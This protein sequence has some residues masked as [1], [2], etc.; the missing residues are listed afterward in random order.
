M[1]VLIKWRNGP[2][3]EFEVTQEMCDQM[4]IDRKNHAIAE[5]EINGV[6]REINWRDVDSGVPKFNQE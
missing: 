1:I 2:Y 4:E 6:M 3:E 5:Y